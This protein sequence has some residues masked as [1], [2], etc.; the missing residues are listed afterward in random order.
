M[1]SVMLLPSA[2]VV[3]LSACA[4]APRQSSATE[5]DS[6]GIT[7]VINRPPYPN[8][9]VADSPV[10]RIGVREGEAAYQLHDVQFAARLTDGRVVVVDGGSQE[11]RWYTMS[12]VHRS[13]LGRRGAGPGEFGNIR[14]VVVTPDDSILVMDF[15]NQRITWLSPDEALVREHRVG[16]FGTSDKRVLG[17]ATDGRL[18]MA[19]L[20]YTYSVAR[21][22]FNPTR[23]SLL[24][25]LYSSSG[26]DSV[27]RLPGDETSTWVSFENGRPS[28]MM[29]WGLGYGHL[30]LTGS[31]RDYF[32][33]AHGE[34]GQLEMLNSAGTLAR[35]SR[36]EDRATAPVTDADR[37]RFV[38]YWTDA[39]RARGVSDV[40]EIEHG[41][42]DEMQTLPEHHTVPPFDRMLVDADDRIWLRDYR[43]PWFAGPLQVWTV[44]EANG[45]VVARVSIKGDLE[46]MHVG[47]DHV[48]VVERDELDVETVA[49][50]RIE[51]GYANRR[52]VA[53][54]T[55][56]V[57]TRTPSD[58]LAVVPQRSLRQLTK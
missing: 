1:K 20:R 27:A 34:H 30:T 53:L 3:V 6:A 28:R 21:P 25:L 58:G 46:V 33:V 57:A 45:H 16:G 24:L 14:S 2:L 44:Y 48:T 22:G 38:K 18:R 49:V 47:Q 12:G 42:R 52:T 36:L 31:T 23:D 41:R 26:V 43:P 8:W 5:S 55:S 7:I 50:Y 17:V 32:I 35:V 40:T 19:N 56:V 39:A 11:V 29:Q 10:V 13:S 37:D 9:H 54:R 15:A 51:R 4:E